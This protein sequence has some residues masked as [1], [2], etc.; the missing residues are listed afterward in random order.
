LYNLCGQN[1]T[2]TLKLLNHDYCQWMAYTGLVTPDYERCNEFLIRSCMTNE[3]YWLYNPEEGPQ[4]DNYA[5]PLP[6]NIV[7]T[8]ENTY[9]PPRRTPRRRRTRQESQP[10]LNLR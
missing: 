10:L 2:P 6:F 5:Q 1:R 7:A 3:T 8:P 4:P 9:H